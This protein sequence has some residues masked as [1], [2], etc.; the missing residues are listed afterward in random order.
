MKFFSFTPIKSP[1]YDFLSMGE[2]SKTTL[3]KERTKIK[4]AK[5]IASIGCSQPYFLVLKSINELELYSSTKLQKYEIE[6]EIIIDIRS[7]G[8]TFLILTE[9]GNVY[10]LARHGKI[11]KYV[12]IGSEIPFEDPENSNFDQIRIVNFFS[13]NNIFVKEIRMGLCS[14]YFLCKGNKLYVSGKNNEGQLGTGTTSDA[15]LP[16]LL[17]NNVSKI[18]SSK[19]MVAFYYITTDNKL[20]VCGNNKYGKLGI[21]KNIKSNQL[22]EI[23]NLGI[24]HNDILDIQ[25]SFF[26][27]VLVTKS[28]KIYSCGSEDFNGMGKDIYTFAEMPFFKNRG[29]K[30]IRIRVGVTQTLV[31]NSNN[32]VFGFG[33]S[34][35]FLPK[36]K[37]NENKNQELIMPQKLKLPDLSNTN[38]INFLIKEDCIFIYN[39]IE[40]NTFLQDFQKFFKNTKYS[41]STINLNNK[42]IKIH[43]LFIESRI[44]CKLDNLVNVLK[45][46]SSNEIN[47]FLKWIYFEDSL[48][49]NFDLIKDIFTSLDLTFPPNE[50]ETFNDLSQNLKNYLLKLYH[51]QDSKDFFI[52][53]L[54]NENNNHDN[55]N[56]NDDN[57]E[58]IVDGNEN[59]RKKNE[60][61]FDKIYVHKFILLARSGLF[62]SLYDFIEN[63]KINQ[64]KDYSKKSKKSLEILI[65]YLY[66]DKVELLDKNCNAELIIEELNDAIEYYQLNTN[67]NFKIQLNNLKK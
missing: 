22:E 18:F 54:K 25:T 45:K 44:G 42:T 67:P 7:G 20:F 66:T 11:G 4:N 63:E 60:Q 59:E 53:I 55:G 56:G 21:N 49:N 43:K 50:N 16:I 1:K 35:T 46:K 36:F 28:G 58:R 33:F 9:S 31:L 52:K 8:Y 2:P 40:T 57:L 29:D 17:C 32:E 19:F 3:W 61:K 13:D 14:N 65:K 38:P 27:S 39:T 48:T 6:N 34:E 41:D 26:H 64:I 23:K 5:Q 37:T 10:S 12:D 15:Q 24:D 30:I 51:E 47:S 62:R